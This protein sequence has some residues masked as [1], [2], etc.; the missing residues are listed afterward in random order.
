MIVRIDCNG[1]FQQNVVHVY[2][3]NGADVVITMAGYNSLGQVLQLRKKSLVVPRSG[4][5]AEQ[6][7]RARLFAQRGLADVIYPWE[8]SPK[9]MAGKLMENLQRKDHQSYDP[10]IRTNGG[11]TAAALSAELLA[12]RVSYSVSGQGESRLYS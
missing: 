7:M 8:L 11:K 3:L 4:P 12:S 10:A 1:A 9:K 5:S 2:Y 6:Q